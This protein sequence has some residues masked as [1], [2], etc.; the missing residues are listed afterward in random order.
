MIKDSYSFAGMIIQ[1]IIVHRV[2]PKDENKQKVLPIVSKK[3]ISLSVT[4]KSTLQSRLTK[5][6]GNKSHG[7]EMSIVSIDEGS[8]FHTASHMMHKDLNGFIEDSGKF[9]HSL[10]DAQFST[11]APSGVLIVLRG[12]VGNDSHPFICVIKAEPQDGFRTKEE[13]DYISV[14]YLE[15]LLLTDAQKLYKM[16][17]LVATTSRPESEISVE[18]YRAFLFD[19]LMTQAE[20]KKAAGYFYQIFLGMSIASSSRKLTQDYYQFSR[21]FIDTSDMTDE[22]KIETH[23]ALRVT[24]RSKKMTINANDFAVEH[25][26]VE[27]QQKYELFM[28]DKGFPQNSVSKDIE[29][30]KSA[31]RKKRS[32]QFSNGVTISTPPDENADYLSFISSD[33]DGY[34]N[35]VIKGRLQKQ[36]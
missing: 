36:I 26:P 30:I 18:D 21:E 15:E 7:I 10:T 33:K 24:L 25:L 17:F 19:H 32:Y 5:S 35:V 29:Y 3:I 9:A 28:Q 11:S 1:D 14:E 2:L 23:E 13:T 22:E 12:R 31:L 27:L 16:G 20:S 4:A 6:L 8:F 34:T